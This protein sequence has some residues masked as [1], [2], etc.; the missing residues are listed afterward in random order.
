MIFPWRRKAEEAA[1]S[2]PA[3]AEIDLAPFIAARSADELALL[4]ERFRTAYPFPHLCVD[5]FLREDFARSLVADFPRADDPAYVEFCRQNGGGI[6]ES[7]SGTFLPVHIDF[8]H[9][10]RTLHHR[11][12]NLLLYLNEQWDDGLGGRP[13]RTAPL[14]ARRPAASRRSARQP[15]R[16][17]DLRRRRH[18]REVGVNR[19]GRLRAGA[20]RRWPRPQR[21]GA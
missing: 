17:G 15:H 13:A 7:P 18:R 6:R 16:A 3:V 20:L 10:P 1:A 9:H 14:T 21:S 8:N 2:V 11:R 5:G 4:R 12:L 19:A